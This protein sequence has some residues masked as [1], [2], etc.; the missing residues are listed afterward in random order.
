MSGN[1]L[2]TVMRV[3]EIMCPLVCIKVLLILQIK[4]S[5]KI[6][7]GTGFS[8]WDKA[9]R[10]WNWPHPA[11]AEVKNVWSSISSSTHL[12]GMRLNCAE[13]TLHLLFL[14]ID[15]NYTYKSV[16][17]DFG[18]YFQIFHLILNVVW[19]DKIT[20]YSMVLNWNTLL[21]TT[22]KQFII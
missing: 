7:V 10:A 19:V 12:H 21:T 14:T 11:I 22:V 13:S 5:W 17:I 4:G 6:K 1:Y 9:A 18:F 8:F 16:M 3:M 20:Y 2:Q 15:V